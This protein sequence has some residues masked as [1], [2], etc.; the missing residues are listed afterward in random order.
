MEL[1][2][3]TKT[4]SDLEYNYTNQLNLNQEEIEKKILNRFNFLQQ[5]GGLHQFFSSYDFRIDEK[6][7]VEIWEKIID[8][9]LTDIF[10]SFAITMSNLKKYTI[11]KNR[12]PMGL[13]NIMQQLRIEQ[14]YI[15][16]EDLKSD[17][18]Y[19]LNFPDLYP[20]PKGYVSSFLNGLQ[21]IINFTGGKIGCKE[22]NDNNEQQMII[23][24]DFT[25]EDKYKN[26]LEN[27]ILFNYEKFRNH[28]QQ[29]LQ[30]LEDISSENGE[31]I[32][33]TINFKKIVNEKYIKKKG[34]IGGRISLSY[35]LQYIECALF[36]LM[37]LKK[38][39]LFEIQSNNKN[40]ECIKLFKNQDD[41]ITEKDQAIA[42]ILVHIEFLDKRINEYQKK[43]DNFLLKAKQYL[44][45]GNKQG[46]KII[47]IKKKNYQKFIENSQN[48][49]T[50][51]EQQL[52]DLKNAE[53][54]ASVTEVLK[55]CLEAEK[56]I[57][58][59]PDDF[60]EVADDLKDAKQSLN[61]INEGMKDFVDEKEED[62]LNK[63]MEK[64][65]IDNQKEKELEFPNPNKEMIDENKEFEQ[66]LK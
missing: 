57:G 17:N 30:V 14:K 34:D 13:N 21:S 46:A 58:L 25:E 49:Q 55:Q 2:Q 61:E 15:T 18:F 51:L 48:T 4:K 26:I 63:E 41:T 24:T 39:A 6:N 50:V 44:K 53:S 62:E 52:F 11:I 45:Q 59:N 27:T 36:Y 23:R 7:M 29:V 28:C 60:A 38:I 37:K 5:E 3:R 65:M 47:M 54:N 22:E 43:V 32:I 56:Q 16:E 31:D 33:P 20:K 64:L 8:Y 66:L 10:S 9:L 12:I 42:K 19:Q 40:I 1:V 35:G